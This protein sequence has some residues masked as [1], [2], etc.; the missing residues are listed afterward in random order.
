MSD[1]E[2]PRRF[3]ISG[4]YKY[5]VFLVYSFV[6]AQSFQV[7]SNVFIPFDKVINT[8]EGFE[9]AL[10]LL[11][12]YFFII[13][14]WINYYKSIT[15]NPHTEN[16]RGIE[17]RFGTARFCID[18]VIIF[19]YNYLINLIPDKYYSTIFVYVFPFIFICFLIWDILRF[20]EYRNEGKFIG[21]KGERISRLAVTGIFSFVIILQAYLFNLSKPPLVTTGDISIW[22]LVFIISTLTIMIIYRRNTA[23]TI[24]SNRKKKE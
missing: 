24:L 14:G 18:L 1:I 15:I 17:T 12:V 20:F 2:F 21:K 7:S 9:N 10:L 4:F 19:L 6:L 3:S 16:K 23:E 8:I 13:S 11:I 22:N 5:A